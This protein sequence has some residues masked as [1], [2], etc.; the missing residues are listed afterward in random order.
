MKKFN[1]KGF[2][3]IEL[4]ATIVILGILMIIAIPMVSQYIKQA[5]QSAFIDTAKA[6]VE[7]ARYAYF[8][9]GLND[10]CSGVLDTGNGGTIYIAFSELRVDKTNDKS[11]FN[12]TI[13][14][15]KSYVKITSDAAGKYTYY[16]A[17]TDG[18]NGFSET[19]EDVLKR[20]DVGNVT[21]IGIPASG[22]TKCTKSGT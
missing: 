11:S 18:Y 20:K 2:T 5:R 12:R 1:N 21:N 13:D 14:L 19:A 10:D 3:L 7:A 17:M 15:N 4:L 8:G 9:D 6:Y 16:V 22:V